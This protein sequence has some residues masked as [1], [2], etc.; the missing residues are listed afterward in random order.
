MP[1]LS[2]S[3][4]GI[5]PES[6]DRLDYAREILTELGRSSD[7]DDHERIIALIIKRAREEAR[8]AEY[9]S[10]YESAAIALDERE[11][12]AAAEAVHAGGPRP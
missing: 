12:D 7:P 3:H 10:A 8:E 11:A 1:Y 5:D 4:L 9:D 6:L 2:T